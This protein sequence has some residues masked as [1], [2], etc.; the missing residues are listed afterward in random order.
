MAV[1]VARGW[2]RKGF[3]AAVGA[4]ALAGGT[5]DRLVVI[6]DDAQ[7]D[8]WLRR[9]RRALGDRL[10]AMGP[11]DP[12]RWLPGADVL[13]HPTRYDASAN[14]VLESLACG[15]P[16]ITTSCDGAAEIVPDRG[17]VLAD[18]DDVQGIA[19]AVRYAWDQPGMGT[20]CRSV[21]E[22]WPASRMVQSFEAALAELDHG[23]A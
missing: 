20:L 19:A 22:E 23:G 5:R 11:G 17:L 8:R 2:F 12:A 16:P 1:F 4:L 15:V 14:V 9:A 18:P 3:A 21:A 10:I 6:G 13:V 7:A